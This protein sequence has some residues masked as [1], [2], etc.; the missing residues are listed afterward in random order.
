MLSYRIRST[1]PLHKTNSK[2]STRLRRTA[3]KYSVILGIGFSYL[4]FTLLTDFRIPCVF[5]ELTDLKCPGCGITRML[6]SI[7]HLDFAS[8]FSYNPFLFITGPFVILYIIL[9]EIKYVLHEETLGTRAN[10][11]IWIE[12]IL[13]LLYGILRNV[14]TIA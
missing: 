13:A 12:I 11:L 2:I 6:I 5:Y 4:I 3:V 1:K 7:A 10:I 9:G 8:A 14:T